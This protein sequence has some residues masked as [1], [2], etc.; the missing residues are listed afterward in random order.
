MMSI[1][2]QHWQNVSKMVGEDDRKQWLARTRG[3]CEGTSLSVHEPGK[4]NPTYIESH[5]Q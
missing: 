2:Y 4:I 5:A 1:S 3:Q